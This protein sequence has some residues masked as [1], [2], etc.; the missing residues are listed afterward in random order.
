VEEAG[1]LEHAA[2]P[3]LRFAL[4][5]ESVGGEAI[6]SVQLNA[7][8][9]IAAARR[10][11]GPAEQEKLLDLF[12]EPARWGTTLKSL[13]W[14][15][16][17]LTIPAF[18][19]STR[20]ELPVACTY[21]FE[22]AAAKYFH[23]LEEGQVPLEFLFSGTF[24]YRAPGGALRTGRISWEEEAHFAL[25]VEVWRSAMERY[26][27]GSA[28]LRLRSDAFERLYRYRARNALPSWEHALEAL[29]SAAGEEG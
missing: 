3:T 23:A 2:A 28:W 13:F 20:V 18:E 6:R 8:I 29:L 14:T 24:F 1:V 21:D 25:P 7:M 15:Q 9:R 19:S 26:F 16:A 27:P 10:G 4:Q 22:V 11:Y 17:N 12:G 5:V